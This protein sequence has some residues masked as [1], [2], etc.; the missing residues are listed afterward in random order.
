[1]GPKIRSSHRLWGQHNEAGF[2][3][4]LLGNLK[5]QSNFLMFLSFYSSEYLHEKPRC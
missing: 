4:E 3:F 5:L 1:M 2:H